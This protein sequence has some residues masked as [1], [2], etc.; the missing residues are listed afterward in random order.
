MH[1]LNVTGHGEKSAT[2]TNSEST[3]TAAAMDM[4]Q[5]MTDT[6]N[7]LQS[8]S[9]QHPETEIHIVLFGA[10]D[11]LCFI[12]WQFEIITFTSFGDR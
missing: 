10:G 6:G 5:R 7:Q 4:P 2:V 8:V 12:R 9:V 1:V 11:L 3:E